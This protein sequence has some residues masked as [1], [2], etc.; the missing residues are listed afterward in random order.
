[1]V[2]PS[3]GSGPSVKGFWFNEQVR[4]TALELPVETA[5]NA[6]AILHQSIV[7]QDKGFQNRVG[8]GTAADNVTVQAK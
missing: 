3:L 2:A 8:M 7:G 4:Q 1:M 5:H 6:L